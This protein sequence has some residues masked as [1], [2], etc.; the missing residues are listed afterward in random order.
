ML[1]TNCT[2]NLEQLFKISPKLKRNLWR[3]LKSNKPHAYTRFM[4]NKTTPYVV[5]NINTTT[6]TM[7]NHMAIIPVHIGRSIIDYVLWMEGHG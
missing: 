1:E 5:L 2:L 6:I 3:K 7:N 4:T